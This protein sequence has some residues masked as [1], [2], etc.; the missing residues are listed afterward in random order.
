EGQNCWA[1]SSLPGSGWN[2]EGKIRLFG[3][4]GGLADKPI[5]FH[6]SVQRRTGLDGRSDI[7]RERE[8]DFVLVA[9]IHER[10]EWKTLGC[11]KLQRAGD[12]ALGHGPMDLGRLPRISG[13]LPVDVPAG[14]QLEIKAGE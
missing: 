11:G 8:N 2:I 13:I 12:H 10:A 7:Q 4:A 5:H 6:G 14:F 3:N 1:A 9:E